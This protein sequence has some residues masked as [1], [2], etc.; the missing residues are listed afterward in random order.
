MS[1]K[2]SVFSVGVIIFAFASNAGA[3]FR[4]KDES[5]QTVMSA[6]V[7]PEIVPK[8]YEVLSLSGRVLEVIPPALTPE[9]IKARDEAIEQGKLEEERKRLEDEK[10]AQQLVDDK[11]LLKQ[12]GEPDVVVSL[13]ERRISE[14]D[15]VIK[16]RKA[17]IESAKK[18]IIENEEQ[19]AEL[20]RNGKPIYKR[21]KDA[22][23]KSR[24]DIATSQSIILEREHAKTKLIAEFTKTIQRLEM[25][26]GK[27]VSKSDEE[28]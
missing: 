13:M 28:E 4:Y 18:L 22:L 15:A 21:I 3:L 23:E 25:L 16:S 7:P 10:R 27:S 24:D 14:I 26:T 5:G 9:Q 12:Y 17:S 19:A 1:S 11:R 2:I 8:G 6:S 20:Q